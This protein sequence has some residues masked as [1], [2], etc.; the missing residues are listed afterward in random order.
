[1]NSKIIYYY[2]LVLQNSKKRFAF[3]GMLLLAV[4]IYEMIAPTG[5]K[6]WSYAIGEKNTYFLDL[7]GRI[8][9]INQLKI[10]GN[11]YSEF[12]HLAFTY[13]PAAIFIFYWIVFPT[14]ATVIWVWTILNAACLYL[15]IF[16]G[17][18][19]VN[20]SKGISK[21]NQSLLLTIVA[22]LFVPPIYECF[23]LGQIGIIL[24]LIIFIDYFSDNKKYQGV[25]M[26][27]AAGVKLYPVLFI[28][29]WISR[30]KFKE[31]ITAICTAVLINIF[32][33]FAWPTSTSFF[34][35]TI[36]FGGQEMDHLLGGI[37]RLGS[38]S[39][40]SPLIRS[41]LNMGSSNKVFFLLLMATYAL[42]TLWIST[43]LYRNNFHVTSFLVISF[44]SVTASIV[45][46]DHYFVFIVLLP[47]AWQEASSSVTFKTLT[48]CVA[49]IY[50]YPWWRFRFWNGSDIFSRVV[51]YASTNALLIGTFLYVFGSL[52][53]LR[54]RDRVA[55]TETNAQ[56]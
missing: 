40:I 11:I 44:V 52:L 16:K 54:K 6:P 33:Y 31:S 5:W 15:I 2:N 23:A 24:F 55:L 38:S 43:K 8:A 35:K 14:Y 39:V 4:L 10:S 26:G 50:I 29:A 12:G 21:I 34:V 49:A 27:I 53:L 48:C 56:L 3:F 13:P 9:N 47:F 51:V 7:T 17:L 46:W 30:R 41:P 19:L 32:A 1:M 28:A 45:T 25:L 22:I 18:S 20:P 42:V 37:K 36:I